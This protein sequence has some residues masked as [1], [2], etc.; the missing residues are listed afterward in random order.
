MEEVRVSEPGIGFRSIQLDLTNLELHCLF[1]NELGGTCAENIFRLL[2]KPPAI[3]IFKE[4]SLPAICGRGIRFH[5]FFLSEKLLQ[6]LAISHSGAT[7]VVPS[8]SAKCLSR[9]SPR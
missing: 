3:V 4:P 1:S 7:R 6:A 9:R 2:I 8:W 5:K